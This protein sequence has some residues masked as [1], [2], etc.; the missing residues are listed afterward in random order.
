MK[1]PP[2][3]IH[4][5]ELH[6]IHSRNTGRHYEIYVALPESYH[7]TDSIYPVLYVLD[8]QWDFKLLGSIYGGLRF[9]RFVREII[10]VGVGSGGDDPGS[11]GF[12]ALDYTPTCP[13]GTDGFGDAPKF[14]RFLSEEL[15]PYVEKEYRGDPSD[16]AI[17]G[18]SFG[19]LF[20]F[21][22]L[23]H[24]PELFRRHMSIS[25]AIDWDARV[26]FRHEEEYAASH[27]AL[28]VRLFV[29][30]GG[31]EDPV[32][33][34]KPMK[35]MVARLKER[36]Y[37]GLELIDLIVDGERHS[38]VKPEAYNR[39]LRAVYMR[40]V[41]SLSQGALDEVVGR[42]RWE[43]EQTDLIIER[44]GEGLV[45]RLDGQPEMHDPLLPVSETE[46][47]LGAFPG[48]L[49]VDRSSSGKVNRVT[50]S[51]SMGDHVLPRLL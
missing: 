23:F 48:E 6:E 26:T 41:V 36:R 28:A 16:R 33:M 51:T 1:H 25:P 27:K 9:D 31:L 29:A 13:A 30:A 42:Y 45:G 35:D 22:T 39:G 11:G 2:V 7:E 38:G 40:P 34:I 47:R 4:G 24:A 49:K 14:L 10:I 21:Y 32:D 17:A 44:E 3:I 12:R 18:S 20:T 50:L 19:G 43:E 46:F 37:Q 8:G 5:A 15:I